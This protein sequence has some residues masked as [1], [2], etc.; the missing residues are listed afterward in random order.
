MQ[1]DKPASLG[2]LSQQSR[3]MRAERRLFSKTPPAWQ[4][5]KI[6]TPRHACLF[7]KP[8]IFFYMSSPR[9]FAMQS[10]LSS[11]NVSYVQ[12]ECRP[13]ITTQLSLPSSGF[14]CWG[15]GVINSLTLS[16]L[17]SRSRR[18]WRVTMQVSQLLNRCRVLPL[19]TAIVACVR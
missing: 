15:W 1:C 16:S 2:T 12:A 3:Y 4:N 6:N 17:L 19:E 18:W 13:T 11:S 7:K 5:A 9:L 10:I 14:G 8:P